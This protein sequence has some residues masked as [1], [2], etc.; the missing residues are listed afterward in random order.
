MIPLTLPEASVKVLLAEN[1]VASGVPGFP[2]A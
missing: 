1:G 2:S